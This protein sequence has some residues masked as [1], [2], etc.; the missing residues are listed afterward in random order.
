MK[1]IVLVDDNPMIITLVSKVLDKDYQLFPFHSSLEALDFLTQHQVD[2]ALL[3]IQMP[4][5]DGFELCTQIKLIEHHEKLPIVILSAKQGSFSR[6]LAYRVG[7]INYL[8]KPFE[9]NELRELIKSVMKV[10][11]NSGRYYQLEYGDLLLDP[12]MK[13]C[14]HENGEYQLTHNEAL[15]L[16]TFLTKPETVIN[17]DFLAQKLSKGEKISFRSVDTH[18][19]ALRKKIKYSS[20]KINS[21]YGEGYILQKLD[22]KKQVA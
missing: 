10:T 14:F 15:I 6:S 1:K 20:T 22:Q 8:E 13:M 17:R 7:A 5:L 2:M 21:V 19:S 18:I 16:E 12:V 3:D 11:S 9:I 4:D